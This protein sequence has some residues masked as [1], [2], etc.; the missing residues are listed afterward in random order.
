MGK[1]L[2]NSKKRVTEN[3]RGRLDLNAQREQLQAEFEPMAVL[4]SLR[5][6][7][8]CE[9]SDAVDTV[10]SVKGSEEMRI[11]AEN[12]QINEEKERITHDINAEIKKLHSGLTSLK[13]MDAIAFGQKT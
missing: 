12:A 4:D 10:A 5:A 13:Q 9:V 7:L 3:V 2:E 8:D 11:A 1:R 6:E